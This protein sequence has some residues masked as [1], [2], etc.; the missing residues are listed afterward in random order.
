[1][2]ELSANPVGTDQA[3]PRSHGYAPSLAGRV[4]KHIRLAVK[5]AVQAGSLVVTFPFAAL[6]AFGR[7]SPLFQF[8]GHSMAL[9]P[10]LPGDYLRVAY[11]HLT[12]DRCSLYSR[13]SFGTFFAQSCATVG[14][15]VYI[16]AYCVLGACNIGDRTQIASHVQT[17]G[18][19]YQHQRTADGQILA[20][21]E[22]AFVLIN[23]GEDC[24]IG[25]SAILMADVG[26]RSTIGAG[27][28]VT[29]PIPPDVVAVGNPARIIKDRTPARPVGTIADGKEEAVC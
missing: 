15:G 27:A 6:T 9:V 4:K 11:Y 8:F 22:K 3:V 10:G 29:R 16:G 19:Q 1:V 24:W 23:V 26:A 13:V 18:G 2:H 17:L 20:A 14:E 28:V 21:D 7:F 25:A 5:V 12:L